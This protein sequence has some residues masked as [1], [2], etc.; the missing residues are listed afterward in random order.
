MAGRCVGKEQGMGLDII[1]GLIVLTHLC[2]V[3]SFLLWFGLGKPTSW[4]KFR[5]ELKKQ[6]LGGGRKAH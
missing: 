3:G 4:A 1:G 6:F 5:A 2:V